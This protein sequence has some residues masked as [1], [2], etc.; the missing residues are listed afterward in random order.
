MSTI[1]V[2]GGTTLSGEVEISGAKNACLPIIAAALL[3]EQPVTITNV[4][5]LQDVSVIGEVLSSL[6]VSCEHQ[7]GQCRMEIDASRVDNVEPPYELVNK[8]RASFLVLGPLLA[9]FGRA[10]VPLPGGCAIGARPVGEH[11]SAMQALGAE[12]R[13]EA[14]LIVAHAERLKGTDIYLNIASVGA[15]ENALMAATLAEGKSTIHNAAEEPEVV[16]LCHFLTRCGVEI[17]GTGTKSITVY[18]QSRISA[19]VEYEVIPDRIEAGTYLL[20]LVG[21]GGSGVVRRARPEHLEALLLKL[22]EC[23][24]QVSIGQDYVEV[25]S[26]AELKPVNLRT[27]IYPGFPTDLQPQFTVVLT[28]AHG[29][30]T[31]VENIFEQRLLSVP[32]LKRMGAKVRI[33]GTTVVIEGPLNGL[34][35]VPVEAHDLRS[36]AALVIAGLMA[37]GETRIDGL[38]HLRRGYEALPR[39]FAALGGRVRY[40]NDDPPA[41]AEAA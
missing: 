18:G 11:L 27:E 1:V 28:A 10:S 21:T 25:R 26:P 38:K 15:T 23:G 2:N 29:V 19:A 12:I 22:R 41:E 30:S 5:Q 14:G 8:M 3:N 16:D 35:G 39:K 24:V 13:Q 4:P 20:A 34:A 36:A 7:G 37:Q 31:V 17:E 6:G 40:E 32:E 9:R 33:S